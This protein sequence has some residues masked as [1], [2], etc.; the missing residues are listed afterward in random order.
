MFIYDVYWQT[1]LQNLKSTISDFSTYGSL[2]CCIVKGYKDYPVCGESFIWLKNSRNFFM[3][4]RRFLS[5]LNTR[6]DM[7]KEFNG[8]L[9]CKKAP[10]L[11][12]GDEV[13]AK[14][15]LG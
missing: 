5:P 13:L 14:V 9:K 2:A 12:S 6:R 3:T 8:L 1:T 11:L 4:D 7:E 10:M 15:P